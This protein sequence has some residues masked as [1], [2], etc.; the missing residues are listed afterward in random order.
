LLHDLGKYS[1]SFIR[2]L[3]GKERG[4]DHWSAGAWAALDLYKQAGIAAA[5]SIQGHHIGLQRGDAASLRALD[6][7]RL[8]QNHPLGLRLTELDAQLLL[9]RLHADGLEL[10]AINRSAGDWKGNDLAWMLDVRMLFS[11]LVDADFLE[12]EAHFDGQ[13]E[14]ALRYRPQGP[15]IHP[16][17]ALALV[18]EWVQELAGR[19]LAAPSIQAVRDEL[20]QSCLTAAEQKPGVFTLTAPTGSGKTLA[21]IAFALRHAALHGL[22]RVVVAIPFLTIIEQTAKAYRDLLGS[23]LGEHW[24]IEHHSLTEV[25]DPSIQQDRDHEAPARLLARQLAEN[26]DAPLV[27]TTNVQVLESLFSNR[28]SACRKLHRLARSVILFDEAQT[29]PPE[30]AVPTL[31]ALAHLANRF[32]STVVFATATQPAFEHLCAETRRASGHPWNPREIVGGSAALFDRA[33]R[34]RVR[35]ETGSPLT[36]AAV[37][38]NLSRHHRALCIVNLKRN[39]RN[40]SLAVQEVAGKAGL[41]HLSTNLCPAHRAAML[42][43]IRDRLDSQDRR[44]CR[45]VATQ[46]V[47]AGVDLDSPVVY[48][49]VG[50]LEA[51]AQGAG[52][53]NRSGRLREAGEVIVFLPEDEAYPPGVYR[54]AAQ[55]TK[56]LLYSTQDHARAGMDRKSH[57]AIRPL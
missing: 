46:C 18:Q 48:R 51:I 15:E 20:F 29:L 32:G 10:P 41:F 22:R 21:M 9:R 8:S 38:E 35:W 24:V 13:A 19:R 36:W 11:T 54:Q 3:H 7:L 1:E 45:L 34:V 5:L 12:T 30:L 25:G 31:G 14:G 23:A 53:C 16:E 4:L 43:Q 49:A 27:V 52:R 40:L 2:R 39:A 26:W 57:Q 6:L 44:P 17:A 50:P 33:R 47:E 55:V 56:A 37:A 28:P 42:A